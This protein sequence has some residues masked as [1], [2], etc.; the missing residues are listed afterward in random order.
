MKEIKDNINKWRHI[1]CSWIWR[2]NIAKMT[3]L[4][5]QI[6]RF[7]AI[8]I[9]LWIT[10]FTGREQTI[11]KLVWKYKTPWVAKVILKKKIGTRWIE[12]PD[13]NENE[14]HSIMSTVCDYMDYRVHGFLQA[15]ILEWVAF[16]SSGDVSNP[17]IKPSDQTQFSGIAVG[18]FTSWATRED[19]NT[20]VGGLSLL[21]QI[22]LI[23]ESN[24]YLLNCRWILYQLTY[25]RSSP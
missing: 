24:Q 4:H 20:G 3:I 1:P 14:S 13:L 16:P 19:K 21:Q 2:I 12:F 18:F 8:P 7:N 23:Q 25:Q 10:F 11:S 5:Q 9:K 6:Y 15:R 17:G 22:F